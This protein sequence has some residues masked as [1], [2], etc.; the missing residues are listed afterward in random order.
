MEDKTIKIS[1]LDAIY[2]DGARSFEEDFLQAKAAKGESVVYSVGGQIVKLKA[3][4]ALRLYREIT[5]ALPP[6]EAGR[7][8]RDV[9]SEVVLD[10]IRRIE[11]L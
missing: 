1:D 11:G 8:D 10:L 7:F 5:N 3:E 4:D 9:P 2:Q 6:E